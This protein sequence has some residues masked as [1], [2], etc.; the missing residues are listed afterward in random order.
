MARRIL[1]S[2]LL[3]LICL[4]IVIAVIGF[5]STPNVDL[6]SAL[7]DV[8]F[9][10]QNGG[11]VTPAQYRGKVVVLEFWK[12]MCPGCRTIL[13]NLGE[14]EAEY[15]KQGVE[16]LAI[17]SI[18]EHD[19][20]REY[21]ATTTFE[22]VWLFADAPALDALGIG[23]LPAQIILDRDGNVAWISGLHSLWDGVEGVRSAL[24]AVLAATP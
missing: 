1:V 2:S 19:A 11:T 10:D 14:D 5:R 16:F 21:I 12:H 22:P 8:A 17:H 13:S 9:T 7:P 23:M 6:E 15:R 20:A 24:N 4:G 18:D 3:V